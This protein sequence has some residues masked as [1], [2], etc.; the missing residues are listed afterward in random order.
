MI[1]VNKTKSVEN[2]INGV[3][4]KEGKKPTELSQKNNIP[5]IANTNAPILI[6]FEVRILI[7]LY[8]NTNLG[9]LISPI[10]A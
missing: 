8:L 9:D 2:L 3:S 5:T 10:T 6:R 7:F 1:E 4:N